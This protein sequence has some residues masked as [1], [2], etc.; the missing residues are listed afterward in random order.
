MWIR[1][2]WIY[3]PEKESEERARLR[4][5]CINM[6]AGSEEDDCPFLIMNPDDVS[7]AFLG[8][9]YD[10]LKRVFKK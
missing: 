10:H 4:R 1:N 5:A 3:E 6:L 2:N 8:R 7:Y 9:Y